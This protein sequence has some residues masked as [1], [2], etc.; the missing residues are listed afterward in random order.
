MN[1]GAE[2]MP[3]IRTVVH[4]RLIEVPAPDDLADGTE[5]LV[6]LVPVREK[7]GLEESEWRD[8]PAALAE[9]AAWLDTIEPVEFAAY[10]PFEEEF[11]RFNVEAVRRQMSGVS[12]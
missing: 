2:T 3:P 12:P 8:D 10:G 4:D 9:W 1:R 6:Q 7:I 5:V 11:Q